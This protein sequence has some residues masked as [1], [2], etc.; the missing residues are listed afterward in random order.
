MA[1]AAMTAGTDAKAT[2]RAELDGV[3]ADARTSLT[4]TEA[5]QVCD[6]YGIPLPE[7]AV[8]TSPQEAAALARGIGFPVVM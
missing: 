1:Q 8:A 2:V 3:K 6:A 5:K 4:A 7:E